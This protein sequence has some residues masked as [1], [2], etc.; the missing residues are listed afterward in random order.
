MCAY[1]YSSVTVVYNVINVLHVFWTCCRV[2]LSLC[3][4]NSLIQVT[5]IFHAVKW[6]DSPVKQ[7]PAKYIAYNFK[8]HGR[9]KFSLADAAS[10]HSVCSCQRIKYI[11]VY[12]FTSL[13]IYSI[14]YLRDGVCKNKFFKQAGGIEV[15]L[16][17]KLLGFSFK[18][19]GGG[20]PVSH[21]FKV[22]ILELL[23][24]RNKTKS[25]ECTVFVR[26]SCVNIMSNKLHF[27]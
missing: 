4:A 7:L 17:K 2:V 20:G 13:K 8:R 9:Y 18:W 5:V 26:C 27:Q 25:S 10:C 19:H 11:K 21:C 24:L 14:V 3:S 15:T 1:V 23:S 12:I 22:L 6:L 16:L